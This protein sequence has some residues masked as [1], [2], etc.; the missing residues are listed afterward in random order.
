MRI[1]R[2]FDQI[3][4]FDHKFLVVN[5]YLNFLE[6]IM[7]EKETFT[8]F[9]PK[10]LKKDFDTTVKDQG[11]TKATVLR[12]LIQRYVADP[13]I[14]NIQPS[15]I[16]TQFEERFSSIIR[17]S[18]VELTKRVEKLESL[19]KEQQKQT[20]MASQLTQES[21]SQRIKELLLSNPALRKRTYPATEKAI[22]KSVPKLED[23][24]VES[25]LEGEDPIADAI[26]EL[27]DEKLV[28]YNKRVKS[29]KWEIHEE[30]D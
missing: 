19:I 2:R 18:E 10:N 24:I 17:T 30:T 25:K 21:L 1:R 6:F 8:F 29:L 28:I 20:L 16:S 23:L 26:N 5:R 7:S 27:R 3:K 22:L 12:Q 13:A 9:V 4:E 14:L 15:E 11:L